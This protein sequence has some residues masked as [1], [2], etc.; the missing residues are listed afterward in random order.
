VR[1]DMTI[2]LGNVIQIAMSLAAIFLAY[3]KLRER[4]V[5]IETQLQ[6]LWSEFERRAVKRG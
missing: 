1:L 3:G 2:T 4:L 5:R 6:P